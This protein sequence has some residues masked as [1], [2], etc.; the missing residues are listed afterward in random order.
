[1]VEVCWWHKKCGS[2][3]QD[4]DSLH[5][6]CEKIEILSFTTT[7]SCAICFPGFYKNM[8]LVWRCN[9]IMQD[10]FPISTTQTIIVTK[11]NLLM[12]LHPGH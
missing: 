8:F 10:S 11:T 7:L 4:V 9:P 6:Q 2:E 1:M 3:Y 5:E 12:F